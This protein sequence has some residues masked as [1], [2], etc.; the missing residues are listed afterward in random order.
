[1]GT[2][3][4]TDLIIGAIKGIREDLK[5]DIKDIKEVIKGHNHSLYGNGRPGITTVLEILE[6]DMVEMK[7]ERKEMR[8][9]RRTI[10]ITILAGVLTVAIST[11]LGV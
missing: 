5:S 9:F 6:K 4:E 8:S 10:L 11:I 7:N 3:K 2:D 1:M